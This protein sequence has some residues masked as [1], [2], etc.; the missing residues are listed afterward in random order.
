LGYDEL[1]EKYPELRELVD[2]AE[3]E[4]AEAPM[5][6]VRPSLSPPGPELLRFVGHE[7]GVLTAVFSPDEDRILTASEPKRS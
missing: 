3:K 6:C 5:R 7:A 4:Q 2:E 1:R